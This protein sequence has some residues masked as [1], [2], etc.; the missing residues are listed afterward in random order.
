MNVSGGAVASAWKSFKLDMHPG[1]RPSAM[2][3]VLHDELEKPLGKIKLKTSGS[4]GGH[5]GIT[6]CIQS[7]GTHVGAS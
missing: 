2:L 7:L 3:V 4:A 6:S 1:E 5:N